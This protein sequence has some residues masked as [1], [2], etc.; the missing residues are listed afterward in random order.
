MAVLSS[1]DFYKMFQGKVSGSQVFKNV[2]NTAAGVASGTAGWAGG[3]AAGAAL[4]SVVPLVGTA[5]GAIAGGILGSLGGGWIGSKVSSVVM[6]KVITDDSKDMQDI[7]GKVFSELAEEYL[8]SQDEAELISEELSRNLS[9][10]DLQNMYSSSNRIK[11]AQNI[12][13]PYIISEVKKRKHILNKD[14]PSLNELADEIE[15][16]LEEELSN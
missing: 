13:E 3:A 10:A 14:L 2:T 12:I 11:F 4:G 15:N 6:D 5:V 16:I 9:S 8:L 7:L 1:V